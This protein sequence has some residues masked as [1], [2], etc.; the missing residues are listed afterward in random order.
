MEVNGFPQAVFDGGDPAQNTLLSSFLLP[1]EHFVADMLYELSLVERQVIESSGFENPDVEAQ[2][3][4]DK[5]V[6]KVCPERRPT[7]DIQ[8]ILSINQAKLLLLE[9]GVAIQKW[10]MQQ[11]TLSQ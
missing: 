5:V 9:W 10:R 1:F 2:F 3:F 6:I 4:L 11:E 8:V 7:D